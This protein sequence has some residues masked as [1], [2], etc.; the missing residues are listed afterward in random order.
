MPLS[1]CGACPGCTDDTLLRQTSG[2]RQGD[3]LCKIF[4]PNAEHHTFSLKTLMPC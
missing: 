2:N 4:R 3:L 1:Y